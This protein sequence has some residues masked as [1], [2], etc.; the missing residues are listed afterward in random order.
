V[1]LKKYYNRLGLSEASSSEDVRRQYRKLA[2]KYHP[3]RNPSENAQEEFLKITEAYEILTGKRKLVHS[4]ESKRTGSARPQQKERVRAARKR[5]YEQ[6]IREQEESERYFKG[7]LK[8]RGWKVVSFSAVVG[9]ILSFCFI[10]DFFLPHHYSEDRITHYSLDVYSS[11]QTVEKWVSLVKT[12]KNEEFWI[13]DL[14]FPFYGQYPDFYVQRS[15]IFQD[16][17]N[18]VSIQRGKFVF[19]PVHYTYFSFAHLLIPIFLFPAFTWFYRRKTITF[20]I[21][22]YLSLYLSTG[23]MLLFLISNMHWLHLLTLGFV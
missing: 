12:A 21:L 19:Y 1:S 22:Y 5:H 8:S 16:P 15:W 13:E 10:L 20:T 11:G 23:L 2:M 17:T 7:L 18:L 14:D 3:D 6:V 9:A 4:L